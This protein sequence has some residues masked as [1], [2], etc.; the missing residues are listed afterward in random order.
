MM[1]LAALGK[2]TFST[3]IPFEYPGIKT[4][5]GLFYHPEGYLSKLPPRNQQ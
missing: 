3:N 5:T 2:P 1:K 4:Y